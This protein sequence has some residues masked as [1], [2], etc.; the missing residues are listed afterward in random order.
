MVWLFLV[1]LLS[2]GRGVACPAEVLKAFWTLDLRA[3]RGRLDN[4]DSTLDIRTGFGAIL[5]EE[6]IQCLL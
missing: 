2:L 1:M 6:F 4:W 3:S 5:H